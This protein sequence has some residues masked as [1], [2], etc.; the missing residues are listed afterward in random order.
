MKL[1]KNTNSRYRIQ[2]LERALDYV[3]EKEEAVQGL[4]GIAAPIKNY[5]RQ[6]LADLGIALPIGRRNMKE[7]L[8]RV[9]DLVKKNMRINIVESGVFENIKG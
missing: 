5:N 4:L 2:A 9:F 3:I 8:D 6:T 7:G 1:S